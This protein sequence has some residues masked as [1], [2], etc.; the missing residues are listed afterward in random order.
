MPVVFEGKVFPAGDSLRVTIPKPITRALDLN[1]G[2]KVLISMNDSQ[3]TLE[4]AK[5]AKG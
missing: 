4:K 2:D 1:A 3:M 5:K